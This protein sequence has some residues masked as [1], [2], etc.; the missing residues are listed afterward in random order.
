MQLAWLTDIHLNFLSPGQ[1]AE[2]LNL[3]AGHEPDA[4]LITG[5]I[6]EAPSVA[7]LL[8]QIDDA[9]QKPI[10]FVLGNHDFYGG[11]IETVRTAAAMLVQRRPN[12]RYL[13][14]MEAV[15]LTPEVGLIGDDGWADA[16]LGDYERSYVMMND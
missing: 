10:Y 7:P 16:R 11:S 6:G 8:E 3:V 14:A 4:L 5:D 13:T 9:I 2:F 12:L 1:I 15:E